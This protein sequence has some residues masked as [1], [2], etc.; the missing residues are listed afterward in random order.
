MLSDFASRC[1]LLL[2]GAACFVTSAA[3]GA[4]SADQSETAPPR[5]PI[6]LALLAEG[7]ILGVG[8]R[9]SGTVSLIDTRTAAVTAEVPVAQRLADLAALPDGRHLLIVDEQRNELL[10]AELRDGRLHLGSRLAVASH[11][12]SVA[13]APDGRLSSVASL[14]LRR[15]TVVRPTLQGALALQALHVIELPFSP[16]VQVFLP[17]AV[18]IVVADAFG[19]KLA[20]VNAAQGRIDAVHT[21]PAHNIRGLAI[22]AS[23]RWLL[24]AHQRLNPTARVDFE[25]VH[26]GTLVSNAVRLVDLQRLG[27]PDSDL[28]SASR[29]IELSTVAHGAADPNG[30]GIGPNGWCYVALG[31]TGELAA[32]NVNG[33]VTNR[34]EVG[35]RPTAVLADPHSGRVYV[36]NTHSDSISVVESAAATSPRTIS[37]GR[38]RQLTPSETG[39]V[40][41]Y[42]ARLAHDGW[43]TCHSCHTDGHTNGATADTLGDGTYGTPKRVLSLLGVGLTD[44]WAWNGG[45]RHLHDQVARSVETTL[46]GAPLAGAQTR[47]L[48]AF[49]QSLQPPPPL[50]PETDDPADRAAIARGRRLFEARGCTAC[51]V[52]A[53]TYTGQGVY[54]VGLADERGERKFNPPSLRGV[55]H[56]DGFFHDLRARTLNEVFTEFGHQLD[57]P[58]SAGELTDLVR[59]LESL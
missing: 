52:P 49:L 34:L 57:E 20:V 13:A 15:L 23:G 36:A 2:T 28:L 54:D 7:R 11:P 48:V 1:V 37:L 27:V 40:L 32:A 35:R 33:V 38:S 41:F 30:I 4:V 53:L 25:D 45:I 17:D 59:F 51:H 19:G 26:W 22:D 46:H 9:H 39:E 24:V 14:W 16:R 43:M 50:K 58:L 5:R 8:N 42:D 56:R 18:R 3:C 12:V 47:E 29:L 31:G 6:A 10:A 44:P 55:G 21:L